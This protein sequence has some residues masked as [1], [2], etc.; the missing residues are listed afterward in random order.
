MLK[1]RRL[2]TSYDRVPCA[3]CR[4]L[5]VNLEGHLS[6]APE[7]RAVVY[8]EPDVVVDADADAAEDTVAQMMQSFMRDAAACEIA[9]GLADLKYT[10]G[11]SRPDINAA[12][13]FTGIVM[14]RLR[15][16]AFTQLQGLL[17]DNIDRAQFEAGKPASQRGVAA[18]ERSP[19]CARAAGDL[20]FSARA[21]ALGQENVGSERRSLCGRVPRSFPTAGRTIGRARVSPAARAPCHTETVGPRLPPS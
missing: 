13:S 21:A 6:R 20:R 4:R 1:R 9:N 14:K 12:K 18:R 11:F 8:S 16:L 19:G 17:A 7:C 15:G 10:H 3:G 2:Q 5:F